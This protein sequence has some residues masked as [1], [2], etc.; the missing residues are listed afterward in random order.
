MLAMRRDVPSP[1]PAGRFPVAADAPVLVGAILW[2]LSVAYFVAQAFA[3]AAF[4]PAYELPARLMSDLGS[5]ACGPLSCS[6]LHRLV[7]GTFVVVGAFHWLGAIATRRAWPLR[8]VSVPARTSL[9]LAGALLIVVG[10]SPE[11]EK[12]A[13]HTVAALAG[14]VCLNLAV[15]GL[16]ASVA[17]GRPW[18][19]ASAVSAGTAGF[20]GLVLFLAGVGARGVTERLA[21]YP[22]T[23]MVAVF[24]AWLLL[25]VVS[26]SR[27]VRAASP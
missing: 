6:P 24:G 13:T 17:S 12:A 7:N 26:R 9:A 19:G 10:L 16:G 25:R 5:T 4:T 3:Q 15:I 14:I 27:G 21:D 2:T 23:A 1:A 18:L 22:A 20:V 8:R 11:N